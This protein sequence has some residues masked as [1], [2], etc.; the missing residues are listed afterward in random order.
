MAITGGSSPYILTAVADTLPRTKVSIIR[1]LTA[2]A[3]GEATLLEAAGGKVIA[4]TSTMAAN[5][6]EEIEI[7]GWVNGL[8]LS[9]LPAGAIVHV[10]FD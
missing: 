10:Y 7:D 9:V 3:T 4:E 8:Y 6:V 1:V 2:A 5:A